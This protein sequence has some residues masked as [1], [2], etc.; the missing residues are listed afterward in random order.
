MK[1]PFRTLFSTSLI[2][3]LIIGACHPLTAAAEGEAAAN[4]Q[5]AP[6]KAGTAE[7]NQLEKTYSQMLKEWS[8]VPVIPH[9][10]Q[11]VEPSADP[12]N[13]DLVV[14]KSGS[15][16]YPSETV[17]L[18]QG[19]QVTVQVE[20]DQEGLYQIGFD[21]L[22]TD[23]GIMPTEGYIQVN[24]SYPFYESRRILFPNLWENQ[25]LKEKYDRYGNELLPRPEKVKVWQHTYA[26]DAS[27]LF[28]KPLKYKLNKGLN[29]ITIAST[30]GDLL[31]GDI[32][33]DS[34]S[35]IDS[36][37][38][39]SN[40]QR[41]ASDDNKDMHTP[42]VI[43]AESPKYKNS[44]SMR[45]VPVTEPGM[46]PYDTKRQLLNA[47]GGSWMDGG[48]AASWEIDAPQD[49]Y[50]KIA[51]KYKQD[52]LKGMPVFREIKVDGIVPFQEA[53]HSAFLYSKKWQNETLGA[54]GEPYE[55]YL[56]KGKHLFTM[57]VDLD[58]IRP[59]IEDIE[60]QM[61]KISRL[62]LEIK[63]L[64]GNRMDAYRD[65]NL[66]EYIPNL[67]QTLSAW[68]DQ[69]DQAYITIQKLNPDMDEIV[70][71]INLR[72]AA[73]QLRSLAEAP[74]K[75]PNRMPLFSEG[76]SSVSQLLGD[77]L[78]RVSQSP[79]LID[80]LYVYQQGN[81]PKANAGLFTRLKESVK[82]FFLSFTKQ[83]YSASAKSSSELNVWINRSRPEVELMQ[84][85]IDEEFTPETGVA[86]K[87]S[88]MP[89][90]NKLVL[91]NATGSQPDAAL[92]VE[93]WIPYDL[94]VRNA[95]VD[96]RK[97]DDFDQVVKPFSKGMMIPLAY[98]N[99]IYALPETQNFWV[100]FYRKDILDNLKLAVPDTWDDVVN[101]L[102]ELQ[103]LGMNF[104]DPLAQYKGFKPL[105]A[106][107]PFIYQ[108]NGE[109][110]NSEGTKTAINSEQAL[111]G[112]KF[113]TDLFT[114][115]NLPQDVPSFYQHFRNGTLPIGISDLTSYLQLRAAAPEIANSWKVALHPGMLQDG[116]VQRWSPAGGATGMIFKGSKHEDEA[117]TFLKWWVSTS[118]QVEYANLQQTTFGP[119]FMWNSANMDAFAQS[120]WPEEDKQ[121]I[122]EQSKWVREAS[123]VPGA[124]MV[125]RELSNV[126]NSVVFSGDNPRTAIDDS[127]IRANREIDKKMEEFGFYKDGKL[128]KPNPVP[129][130]NTIDKWVEKK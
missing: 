63:K 14:A 5:S 82:R 20:V 109:L 80:K 99:G 84:K 69:L 129:T 7:M 93:S 11:L 105:N 104:F 96:L 21:Y 6:A 62:S 87:L 39:Y 79:M 4:E 107:T 124:Y 101:M 15:Q 86:V 68:A 78:Q 32:T 8:K 66:T 47:F 9:V 118:V 81:L 46:T 116:V 117:W 91:A 71:L 126:Y 70:E 64:T 120:A 48:Q 112:I 98:G 13:K 106:T 72:T 95:A 34:P 51:M 18:S 94:A 111:K 54:D 76:G 41:D 85:L 38:T 58:P 42:I 123:R 22:V 31:L 130:I 56:T 16:G 10:D 121:V 127:V 61:K 53:A 67:D 110:F 40:Q 44:S 49:G 17:R 59:L 3:S 65:W 29:T 115:Y 103:R 2:A 33:V 89:D 128:V 88:I 114:I 27:Y 50:Y 30:R 25:L 77:L 35:E 108:A 26:I 74:D 52:A 102:P 45:A 43:E 73:K 122:L 28:M 119:L 1:K 24:H 57:T 60:S 125:E 113:M 19:S 12:L 55:F 100:M 90:Q 97:F 37:E 23:D 92:G 75:L 36:Y 83:S